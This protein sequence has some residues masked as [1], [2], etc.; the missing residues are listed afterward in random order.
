MDVTI[1]I[2]V[3]GLNSVD[4]FPDAGGYVTITAFPATGPTVLYSK[5]KTKMD[6]DKDTGTL[7]ATV[8]SGAE[9]NVY[10]PV[11]DYNETKTIPDGSA[12]VNWLE[13]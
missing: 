10:I 11:S 6:Y 3:R 8:P 5:Q 13:I 4:I 1:S 2:Q 12:S 9:V 7:S